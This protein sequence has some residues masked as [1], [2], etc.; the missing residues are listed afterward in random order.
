MQFLMTEFYKNLMAGETKQQALINAQ[1]TLQAHPKYYLPRYWAGF[2][3]L[4]A[5]N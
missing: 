2:I 5:L 1:K 3:L 4:D